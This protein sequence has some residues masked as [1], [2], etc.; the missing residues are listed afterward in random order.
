M[1]ESLVAEANT[2]GAS[3]AS[4]SAAGAAL[5]VALL[6]GVNDA[7][8]AFLHPLLP[9]IMGKLGLSIALAATLAMTL[10]LAAS[11]VQPVMGYLADRYGRR[12]FVVLGPLLSGVCLSMIGLAPSF[13]ILVMLLALG[14]LGS[15]A[16]HPPGASM[17][18]R[19][20]EGAG[21]GVR[22]SYFSFGGAAGY[23]AGPLI[24]VGLVSALGLERLWLA[25]IPIV[26]LAPV[27]WYKLPAEQSRRAAEPPPSMRV[28]L[29]LLSGPLGLVFG[30]S[31]IAAF[32]QRVFLTME[33]I[34]VSAAGGSEAL[35][36]L[37]LSV[38]LAGQA[39]G[40]LVGGFLTDRVDRRI[41]LVALS[42]F[43]FPAHVA[44]L[45]LPAG[46][47]L[48]LASAALAGLLN[49]ALLPPVIVI[50]QELVPAGAALTSGVVMGLAWALGSVGV[51]GTGVLGDVVGPRTAA[52]VSVPVMLLAA[53]LGA[54][55][56]LA[57]HRR[58]SG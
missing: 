43:S 1:R 50:A 7:Y 8:A 17:A 35:G 55:R 5:A 37:T 20:T 25:M 36:A 16:F 51:L 39:V 40:S 45:A 30:V 22:L 57:A 46:S 15:A 56:R 2:A 53:V 13:A 12:A 18:A 33:P 19:V 42:V 26:V 14:G 27:A 54:N 58:P 11:L 9:R 49:M 52:L 24:A 21:S 6:H 3:P 31:A 48:A 32:T 34:A 41:V 28:V 47:P 29:A 4:A 44:A 10:S 23:A 38:Y